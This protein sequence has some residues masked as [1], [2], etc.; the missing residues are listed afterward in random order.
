MKRILHPSGL[1]TYEYCDNDDAYV[2]F[3]GAVLEK[4]V[5]VF[6][7]GASVCVFLSA[8][9]NALIIIQDDCEASNEQIKSYKIPIIFDLSRLS[10]TTVDD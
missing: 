5:G 6:E 3:I 9:Q 8:E 4:A 2:S 10:E 1:F 7:K